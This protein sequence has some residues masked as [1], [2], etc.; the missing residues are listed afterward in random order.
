MNIKENENIR[1]LMKILNYNDNEYKMVIA[2]RKDLKLPKGKM[3]A[4][5]AHA[6]VELALKCLKYNPEILKEWQKNGSKKVVVAVEN[7]EEV[8][9]LKE[10]AEN[11]GILS[12]VIHDAGKTVV[13]EGTLTCIGFGPDKAEK[14]DKITGNLKLIN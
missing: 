14:I 3:A 6:A 13:E 2:V 4:Q 10:K 11:E 1:Q 8:W 5:V 7:Q 12:T 9:K